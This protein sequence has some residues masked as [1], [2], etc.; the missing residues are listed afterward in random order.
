MTLG[1]MPLNLKGTELSI[2]RTEVET[3]GLKNSS[4]MYNEHAKIVFM[5][6]VSGSMGEKIAKTFTDQ[7][8]WT[9]ELLAAIRQELFTEFIDPDD[10]MPVV[11][12]TDEELKERVVREDLLDHFHV[13]PAI[14]KKQTA[15]S[16]R[17]DVVKKLAKQEIRARFAKH[18]KSRIAVIPFGS[19]PAVLFDD[20]APEDLWPLLDKL[21]CYMTVGGVERV[22]INK[23]SGKTE[24]YIDGGTQTG[25]GTDILAAIREAMDACRKRPS[26]V[27]IHH[28]ILVSDGEDG[29]GYTIGTWV[30]SFK[31]SGIVLDYI[32]IG[33]GGINQGIA[34][35]CKA[36]GG[37]AVVVNTERDLET[38]F[39]A[40]TTRLLAPPSGL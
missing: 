34:N 37:N 1:N 9:P 12:P 36:T 13:L 18:P 35:A 29:S 17:L 38:K 25:G 3:T 6:D 14:G 30:D 21:S 4:T 10:P 31:A 7:Y 11:A 22:E 39:I 15:L 5:F 20:G 40:A 33:D 32:H 16:S 27:G 19:Q 23:W 2:K 28:F 24:T 26:A 8:L